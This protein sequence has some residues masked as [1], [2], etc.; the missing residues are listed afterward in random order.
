MKPKGYWIV[1]LDVHDEGRFGEYAAVVQRIMSE[2]GA[3]FLVRGG[4]SE[5]MAGPAHVRITVIEFRLRH[6]RSL[7]PAPGVSGRE[8]AARRRTQ[9]FGDDRR[10]HRRCRHRRGIRGSIGCPLSAHDGPTSLAQ[11]TTL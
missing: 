10:S 8:A 7:L 5:V 4:R 6:G 3:R 9:G 11:Q 2:N 1:R